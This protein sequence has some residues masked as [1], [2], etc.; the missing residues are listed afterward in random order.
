MRPIKTTKQQSLIDL[1]L[2]LYGN[3]DAIPE[4]M[5]LNELADL[6][7]QDSEVIPEGEADLASPFH[8]DATV[9][10]D[11]TSALVNRKNLA[12]TGN[13][14]LTTGTTMAELPLLLDTYPAYAAYSLRRL[15]LGYQGMAVRIRRSSDNTEKDIGFTARGHFDISAFNS[16]VGAGQGYVTTW[17]DQ[18]GNGRHLTQTTANK[19]PKITDA[20]VNGRPAVVSDGVDDYLNNTTL[21]LSRPL[22][23]T[24]VAKITG[25]TGEQQLLTGFNASNTTVIQYRKNRP[26]SNLMFNGM[27]HTLNPVPT[28]NELLNIMGTTTKTSLYRNNTLAATETDPAKIP[29]TLNL[30]KFFLFVEGIPSLLNYSA[31]IVPELILWN[32]DETNDINTIN[33]NL[34][35]YYAAF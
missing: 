27:S 13:G 20:V 23:I 26:N 10:Y 3:P 1:A 4:L 7:N 16:F 5:R 11:E 6:L 12:Y 14:P 9:L 30:V 29:L 15:R 24:T 2:Q 21:N 19:Q 35:N 32:A 8:N 34:N 31:A 22:T 28:G 17:Y 33:I 25:G 18:T